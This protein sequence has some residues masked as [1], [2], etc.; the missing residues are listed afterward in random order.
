M[1]GSL[2]QRPSLSMYKREYQAPRW[3]KKTN[4]LLI[5]SFINL[6]IIS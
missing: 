2:E 1:S 4:L 5:A 3:F 6:Y